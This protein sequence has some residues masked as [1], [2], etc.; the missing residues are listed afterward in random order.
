MP[1]VSRAMPIMVTMMPVILFIQSIV[2]S[3]KF[4]LILL[5]THEKKN[6]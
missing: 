1:S 3:L 4:F 5:K 6:Q 2:P